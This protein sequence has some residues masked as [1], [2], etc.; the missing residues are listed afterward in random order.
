MENI[1]YA[2]LSRVLNRLG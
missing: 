2:M 1:V